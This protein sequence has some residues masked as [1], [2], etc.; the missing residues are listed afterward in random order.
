MFYCLL[1]WTKEKVSQSLEEK[2][3]SSV[4]NTTV[5]FIFSGLCFYRKYRNTTWIQVEVDIRFFFP[6]LKLAETPTAAS[7]YC[8]HKKNS[9]EFFWL[10]IEGTVKVW[11]RKSGQWI[12]R[13]IRPHNTTEN[14][15]FKT[16]DYRLTSWWTA[17]NLNET[18]ST[19]I[20]RHE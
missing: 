12:K 3:D 5:T 11:Q 13:C 17:F 19:I 14:D 2:A 10:Q 20:W 9:A 18:F 4:W 8:A 1:S 16:K 15:N 7:L 6:Y